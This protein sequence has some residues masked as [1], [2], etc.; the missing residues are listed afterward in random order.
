MYNSSAFKD[1]IAPFK[2]Q[3]NLSI[4]DI[5]KKTKV[6]I[7]NTGEYQ[8]YMTK[9]K[10]PP[11]FYKTFKRSSSIESRKAQGTISENAMTQT[12][13]YFHSNMVYNP[14]FQAP[15]EGGNGNFTKTFFKKDNNY[16]T[17][18]SQNPLSIFD[19]QADV[20]ND[21]GYFDKVYNLAEIYK[22]D[23]YYNEM[24]KRKIEYFKNEKNQN[25][26]Y[27]LEK[28]YSRT[29]HSHFYNS[30]E[31]TGITLVS[32][33]IRFVN[34]GDA[35]SKPISFYLPFALLP[36]YYFIDIET[37]KL[38]LMSVL[39]FNDSFTDLIFNEEIIY[40]VINSWEE[41]QIDKEVVPEH[42]HSVYKFNWLTS[43]CIYEVY[44]R[45]I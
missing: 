12:L 11:S 2:Y 24:L 13:S 7:H 37:F 26:T 36:V 25:L 43:K 3:N 32:L 1:E 44:I 29:K 6:M 18:A 40:T 21:V 41:Y 35:K 45:Y 28:T 8:N 5:L 34:S 42:S 14:R 33:E 4:V 9:Y 22:K 19:I 27:F 31:Q 23:N 20:F 39:T 15:I 38:L 10:S 30:V 16:L 17:N